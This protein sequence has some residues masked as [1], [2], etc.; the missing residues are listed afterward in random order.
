MPTETRR[1]PLGSL[2]I[3]D[4]MNDY[5]KKRQEN[6]KKNKELLSQLG[7]PNASARATRQDAS[8]RPPPAK[9]LKTETASTPART[10]ARLASAKRPDYNESAS[11]S[12]ATTT[13]DTAS[14]RR[15]KARKAPTVKAEDDAEPDEVLGFGPSLAEL[16]AKS[17]D[18]LNELWTSWAQTGPA[19]SRSATAGTLHFADWPSFTPNK[20]PAEMLQEG[21]F[22]GSYFRPLYSK[23]LGMTITD[24]WLELPGHW[25]Q[26]LSVPT[27]LTSPTY[28]IEV[29]KYKAKCGQSIEQWEENGW[30]SHAHD[31]R[32]WFQWYCRFFRGR[33]CDDDAR[34]VGRW[35]RCVGPRGRW[36]RALLKKYGQLGI[37]DVMPDMDDDAGEEDRPD[38]SPTVHQTCLQW[39][40]EIRQ[41]TLDEYWG[42]GGK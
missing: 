6:I 37:R 3:Q 29:N 41:E 17:L 12:T 7:L 33:R 23:R 19:P 10:S 26:G 32:G 8:T 21:V 11:D 35:D 18:E 9:R 27:F 22:G 25:L 36:R 16:R 34:Q 24:D 38:V 28:N 30:I 15:P 5:E 13:T 1:D 14:G 42:N 2:Y 39:A 40:F 4:S 31:V 20:T